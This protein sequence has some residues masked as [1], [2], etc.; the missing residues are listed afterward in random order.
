MDEA[1]LYVFDEAILFRVEAMAK[2][3]HVPEFFWHDLFVLLGRHH[4]P[5]YRWSVSAH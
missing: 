3:F 2:D 5:S 4:R 1:P